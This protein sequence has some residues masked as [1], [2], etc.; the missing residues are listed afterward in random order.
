MVRD[1]HV[2]RHL[3]LRADGD[4][5]FA[6][7]TRATGGVVI[8]AF[9]AQDEL[10]LVEQYRPP[11]RRR[12]ISLPAGLTGDEGATEESAASARRELEEETGYRAERLIELGVGPSSPG[13][14]SEMMT[15]FYAEGVTKIEN[16]KL[17]EKEEITPHAVPRA[18]LHAWLR[19]REAEGLLI[20]YKI[21]AALY[22]AKREAGA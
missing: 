13:L 7:R 2:G 10:L 14:T 15:F 3:A 8:L 18:Q 16:A 6:E 21:Y 11:V 20:D 22:L 12:V 4:W 9:T 5:E 1:L 19:A 17:D